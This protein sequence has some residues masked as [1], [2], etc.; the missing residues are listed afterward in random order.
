MLESTAIECSVA[1]TEL[2][3][4]QDENAELIQRLQRTFQEKGEIESEIERLQSL[5]A[6][7][8]REYA[9]EQK[10]RAEGEIKMSEKKARTSKEK[11]ELVS[12]IERLK[13]L[14]AQLEREYAHEQKAR[15]EGEIKMFEQKARVSKSLLLSQEKE[16][17]LKFENA[18]TRDTLE[19]TET[20]EDARQRAIDAVIKRV[21]QIPYTQIEEKYKHCVS[22]T[23]KVVQTVRAPATTLYVELGASGQYRLVQQQQQATQAAAPSG[24]AAFSSICKPCTSS[25]IVYS[26]MYVFVC[27]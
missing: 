26:G 8:E 20:I 18:E 19:G 10:A 16:K 7:L 1:K 27:V 15:A 17:S 6:Q 12:E 25:T 13:S 21:T 14:K 9:H 22:N 23:T 2:K 11:G 24:T 5:N 4:V 3:K